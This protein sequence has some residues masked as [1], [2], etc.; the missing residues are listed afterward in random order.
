[1]TVF[2]IYCD[3]RNDKSVICTTAHIAKRIRDDWDFTGI[4]FWEEFDYI[5][6]D[7]FHSIITD[8]T[9]SANAP[10]MKQFLDMLYERYIKD[11]PADQVKPKLVF[12]SATP[13]PA[14][15]LL[16]GYSARVLDKRDEAIF[17]K[18]DKIRFTYTKLSH[19]R[20]A[21]L[22][23]NGK[24]VV[25]YMCRFEN[26]DTLIQLALDSGLSQSNIAV[27]VSA[28]EHNK[29]L[30][31]DYND[32]FKNKERVEGALRSTEMLPQDIRLFITNSKNKEGINI[33]TVPDVLIIEDHCITDIIQIC[34][35]MRNGVPM[36][37]IIC[38]APQHH[39]SEIYENER[40]L[41]TQDLLDGYNKHLEKRIQKKK[42]E[43]GVDN[44]YLDSCVKTCV[45][46]VEKGTKYICFNPFTAKCEANGCF[47][48]GKGR[49]S[50]EIQ[51][52]NQLKHI[53]EKNKA[54]GVRLIKKYFN[55]FQG[56]LIEHDTIV[57][58]REW[59]IDYMTQRGW[60]IGQTVFTPAQEAQLF[61]DL[62]KF[63]QE[64]PGKSKSDYDRL[65]YLLRWFGF[66]KE[67]SGSHTIGNFKI[68]ERPTT[69][70]AA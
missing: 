61:A 16:T 13:E 31:N 35:R 27:S 58:K 21:E 56:V 36:A 48:E 29:S 68:C 63:Y 23:K 18:P 42:L 49:Y 34:G 55:Y 3:Y 2:L 4:Y 41:Q 46:R 14:E 50:R 60:V 9:F 8:A 20:I 28:A 51:L 43:P 62:Y 10:A 39:M 57:D 5:V 7:E 33:K 17:I 26:M 11:K 30:E 70:T 6:F 65:G 22:L 69:D 66:R 38:D 64:Y 24:T 45:D 54:A 15:K 52:F 67:P 47:I 32:I 19:R 53:L 12:M 37:E 59:L 40:E 44:V 1:M 25:Y